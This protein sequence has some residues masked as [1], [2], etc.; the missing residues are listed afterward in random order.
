MLLALFFHSECH[1][2][3]LPQLSLFETT[4]N[5]SQVA[6]TWHSNTSIVI[7]ALTLAGGEPLFLLKNRTMGKRTGSKFKGRAQVGSRR[8]VPSLPR[9][10]QCYTECKGCWAAGC[11]EE[12]TCW[13]AAGYH[14]HWHYYSGRHVLKGGFCLIKK[15]GSCMDLPQ[16]NQAPGNWEAHVGL[17]TENG[18]RQNQSRVMPALALILKGAWAVWKVE[19][20]S[21]LGI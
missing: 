4:I 15:G 11:C 1:V 13:A 19:F 18:K 6:T 17:K 8:L 10:G 14:L 7:T 2:K 20:T 9:A 16:W 21:Y 3:I 5:N 12:E